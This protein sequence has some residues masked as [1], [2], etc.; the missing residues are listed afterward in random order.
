MKYRRIKALREDRDWSQEELTKLLHISRNAYVSYENGLSDVPIAV[1]TQLSYIY[2]TS[3]DY[4][5]E[6]TDEIIPHERK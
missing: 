1:L 4:L 6:M 5:L 3:V 2:E